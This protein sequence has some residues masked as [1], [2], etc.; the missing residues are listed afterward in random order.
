LCGP[1]DCDPVQNSYHNIPGITKFSGLESSLDWDIGHYFDLPFSLK[2]YVSLTKMFEY[3]THEDDEK[4]A[5]PDIS[6]L[7]VSYG[8]RF[9]HPD[10]G[11]K[12]SVNAY[13]FGDIVDPAEGKVGGYNVVNL[14]L[15]KELAALANA[16]RFVIGLDVLNATNQYYMTWNNYPQPGRYFRFNLA[17]E[18]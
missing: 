3:H 18:Y 16:G 8:V 12:A 14:H 6:D 7:N 13:Y 11:F 2:P 9:S 4:Q 17:Y 5:E 1:P 15:E 10:S